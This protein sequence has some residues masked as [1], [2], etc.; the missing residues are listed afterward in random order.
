MD[1]L[2]VTCSDGTV[3]GPAGGTGG[4]AASS[5]TCPYGF[6]SVQVT[7]DYYFYQSISSVVVS[8]G[9]SQTGIMGYNSG[10]V[11]TFSSPA[12][13]SLNGVSGTQGQLV[14]SLQFSFAG[15]GKQF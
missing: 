7:T 6:S 12:G 15:T 9:G 8:C 14:Y 1:A 3:L 10:S 2:G 5:S 13:Q 11:Q 4:Y